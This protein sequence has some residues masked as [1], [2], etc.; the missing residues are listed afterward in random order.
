MRMEPFQI[1]PNYYIRFS[2]LG[3]QYRFSLKTSNKKVAQQIADQIERGL[4]RGL[5]DSLEGGSEGERILTHLIARPGLRAEEAL[6]GL[7]SSGKQKSLSDALDEY[8]ENCK[9]E[10][11]P[12][13]YRNEVRVF[14]AFAHQVKVSFVHQVVPEMVEHWRNARIENVSKPTVNRELKMVKRFF[15]QATEKGYL[16]KSPADKVKTYREPE[17]VIRHLS[18]GEIKKLLETAPDDLKRVITFFLLTGL[19]YGELCHL[20][21]ADI[22]FRHRQ[23]IVQPKDGWAPKNFKKRI[24]PMHPVVEEILKKIPRKEGIAYIFP[25]WNGECS[26]SDLRNRLY[27]VFEKAKVAGNV[28]DLRSTFASNA[29]MSGMPIYTVSKL[30]GHHDVKITEKHYAHLAPDYMG[31]A[32]TMLQPKWGR[33]QMSKHKMVRV[34]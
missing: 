19:R 15:K 31:N 22:D 3:K 4:E 8:L 2:F 20:T 16:Q 7:R 1:G 21:W 23:V 28:K 10:H 18:D 24:I 11:S 6:D 17:Q 13:N 14:N 30:L 26:H 27:R 9:T 5:F 34:D 25:D 12:N 29:V 32:I 33:L